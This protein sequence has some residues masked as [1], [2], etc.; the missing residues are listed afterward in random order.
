[1][2]SLIPKGEEGKQVSVTGQVVFD[3]QISAHIGYNYGLIGVLVRVLTCLPATLILGPLT[4]GSTR[5]VV[6]YAEIRQVF[7]F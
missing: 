6:M 4:T 5:S 1:M 7:S 2:K 3:G